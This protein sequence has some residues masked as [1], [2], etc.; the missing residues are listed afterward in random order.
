AGVIALAAGA[1]AV[2]VLGEPGWAF[3][4]YA[5]GIGASVN[6]AL[7]AIGYAD[8]LLASSILLAAAT[9]AVLAAGEEATIAGTMF[10]M[11][12]ATLVHWN[13]AVMFLAILVGLLVLLL[14]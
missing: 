8:T 9:A 13:F 12:G 7:I 1:F 4:V 2:R 6:V 10:L 5:V 14:P 3:P 11:S